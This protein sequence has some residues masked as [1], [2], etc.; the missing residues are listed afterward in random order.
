MRRLPDGSVVTI[1]GLLLVAGMVG[2]AGWLNSRQEV[3][4]EPYSPRPNGEVNT[5][6]LTVPC[7]EAIDEYLAWGDHRDGT[8]NLEDYINFG[9]E[10]EGD[11][12]Q[13]V[14]RY[15]LNS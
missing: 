1:G 13:D 2:G 3:A 9:C 4:G 5:D 8:W 11:T 7:R 15:L 12:S 14:L 10:R 6:Y